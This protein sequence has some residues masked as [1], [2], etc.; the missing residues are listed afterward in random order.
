MARTLANALTLQTEATLQELNLCFCE[1]VATV[2]DGNAKPDS[3]VVT[4][5]ERVDAHVG[6]VL[7]GEAVTAAHPLGQTLTAASYL[8]LVPTI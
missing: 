8:S 4:M 7:S 1:L 2:V 5:L 6:R 3:K